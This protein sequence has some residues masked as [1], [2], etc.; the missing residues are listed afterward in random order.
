[1]SKSEDGR[2]LRSDENELKMIGL[3]RPIGTILEQTLARLKRKWEQQ[4]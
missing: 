4:Y 2:I 3:P 1:M